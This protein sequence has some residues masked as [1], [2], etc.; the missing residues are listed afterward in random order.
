MKLE[1]PHRFALLVLS[2]A[3][4][5]IGADDDDL[6]KELPR[7]KPLSVDGALGSV[8]LHKGF[9]LEPVAVERCAHREDHPLRA[10]RHVPADRG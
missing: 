4:F 9:R 5:S 7:I 8:Q 1:Q 2:L 3:V 10:R 6:A